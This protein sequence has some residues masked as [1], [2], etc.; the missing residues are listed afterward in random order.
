MLAV[1]ALLLALACPSLAETFGNPV[2]G[3][4]RISF[5]SRQMGVPVE[6][7]FRRF[8]VQA[9]FDAKKPESSSVAVQIDTGSASLGVPQVDMELPKPP[10]FDAARHPRAEFRSTSV[11]ALGDGR[12]EIAGK[13]TLK[14][15]VRELVVPVTIAQAGRKLV[16]SGAFPLKRLDFQ[17]GDQEWRDTSL[18]ADEVQVRF[19]LTLAP[20]DGP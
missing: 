8:Q 5:V 19:T 13:L 15:R 2:L 20:T 1:Q 10:W 4:S 16:A 6:G 12:Y 18:V 11:S 9:A 7:Q 17:V 14:G 3:E